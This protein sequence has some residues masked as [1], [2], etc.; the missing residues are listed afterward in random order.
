METTER[1]SQLSTAASSLL[2]TG[3]DPAQ[4]TKAAEVC[5]CGIQYV[6]ALHGQGG[7]VRVGGQ[8]P[9]GPQSFKCLAKPRE[10]L[11]RRVGYVNVRKLKPAL[12]TIEHLPHGQRPRHNPSVGGD[13]D[14]AQERSPRKPYALGSGE[15]LIPPPPRRFVYRR[16]GIMSVNENVDVGENHAPPPRT[17]QTPRP[18]PRRRADSAYRGRSPV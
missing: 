7:E 18:P 17:P 9:R 3:I 5:I 16:V 12:D 11:L 13:A 15:A 4:A 6:A 1:Q 2:F 8:I 10:V 14:K